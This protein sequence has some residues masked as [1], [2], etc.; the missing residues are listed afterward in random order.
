MAA[1]LCGRAELVFMELYHLTT[2]KGFHIEDFAKW[3]SSIS[4]NLLQIL[5]E[6]KE[7][8]KDLF[9]CISSCIFKMKY[10]SLTSI[11]LQEVLNPLLSSL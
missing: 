1:V 4:C 11:L 10:I 8:D 6:K 5:F 2:M 7:R 3:V 9:Y